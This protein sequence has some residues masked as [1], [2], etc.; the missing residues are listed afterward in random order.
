VTFAQIAFGAGLASTPVG[1]CMR[2]LPK[3]PPPQASAPRRV[4]ERRA[5]QAARPE[6]EEAAECTAKEKINIQ[7]GVH[8]GR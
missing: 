6:A 2:G 3:S 5:N 8:H 4:A 1:S 7:K